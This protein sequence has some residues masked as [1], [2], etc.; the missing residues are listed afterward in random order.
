MNLF[1]FNNMIPLPNKKILILLMKSQNNFASSTIIVAFQNGWA[2]L[3]W[4][5]TLNLQ[6]AHDL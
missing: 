3:F 4:I 2:G 1:V 6:N 5:S